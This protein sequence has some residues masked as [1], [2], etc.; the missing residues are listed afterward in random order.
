MVNPYF[1]WW[2]QLKLIVHI[3]L[4]YIRQIVTPNKP[5]TYLTDQ[6]CW[7]T[8]TG[9]PAWLASMDAMKTLKLVIHYG[10]FVM[11]VIYLTTLLAIRPSTNHYRDLIACN[12]IELLDLPMLVYLEFIGASISVALFYYYFHNRMHDN[13]FALA[14]THMMNGKLNDIV[15]N[16]SA[17]CREFKS[18]IE[19][20]FKT[21]DWFF[22]S[23]FGMFLN[24]V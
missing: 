13:H 11:M 10:V 9:H 17:H 22:I 19:R 23:Y 14:I 16:N 1:L 24:E 21:F 15:F 6:W 2:H 18:K 3:S 7:A 12:F 8:Q 4:D 20:I 5:F